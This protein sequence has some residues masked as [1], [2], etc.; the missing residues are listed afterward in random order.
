MYFIDRKDAGKKLA[1]EVQRIVGDGKQIIVYALPR[2][3]IIPA[4]EVAK[5]LHVPL[6]MLITRKIG[7]PA[8]PEYALA[9]IAENG[10]IVVGNRLEL[11]GVD[12]AW[13]KNEIKHE[14]KEVKRRRNVYFSGR[15]SVAVKGK[16]AL[17]VDDGIATGLTMEAAVNDVKKGKPLKIIIAVPVAP[18]EALSKISKMV[19]NVVCLVREPAGKFLGSIGDYYKIFPQ[20]SDEE[21][22]ALLNLYRKQD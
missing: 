14:T 16:T 19:D 15:K 13:L 7:H 10:D 17:I 21:V 4:L 3:G 22:V 18:E 20:V 9:A 2:G 1:R 11:L 12:Q 6:D 5:T 8:Q